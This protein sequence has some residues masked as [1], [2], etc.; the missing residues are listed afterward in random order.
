MTGSKNN[1]LLLFIY[2]FLLFYFTFQNILIEIFEI[3]EI[4]CSMRSISQTV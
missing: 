2:L 3:I 1:N 4:S